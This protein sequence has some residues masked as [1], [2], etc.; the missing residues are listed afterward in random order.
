M[1]IL[2]DQKIPAQRVS[3]ANKWMPEKLYEN[4]N[5]K[6]LPFYPME[7]PTVIKN[8]S[9]LEMIFPFVCAFFFD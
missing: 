2:F 5:N 7:Y 8:D 6:M 1:L 9:E 3:W 4:P